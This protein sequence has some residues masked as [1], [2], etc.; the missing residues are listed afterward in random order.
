[1]KIGIF[2]GTFNPVHFGHLRAAEEAREKLSLD[3]VL[4]IPSGNPPLKTADLAE[5]RHR[6][7]MTQLAVQGNRAFEVLD[8]ECIR[9]ERS[10]TVDTLMS[11]QQIYAGDELY[12]MLGIDAFLDI[13]NWWMPDRLVSLANFILFS[14]PGQR[15][16][17]LASSPYLPVEAEALSGLERIG[18]GPFTAR[19]KTGKE[20]V[21]L[22]VTAL[23]ISS[24]D[25]R[26]RVKSGA[27]IKYLLPEQVES[28]IISNSLYTDDK[29]NN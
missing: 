10:Y 18:A 24:T 13:P 1:M 20:V 29:K 22:Q 11:L 5:A 4:F 14:R 25:I 2:G 6:L 16:T 23:N 9:P 28:F 26:R 7:R 3:K 15:F 17:D 27:S 21:M 12:F 19:L 8:M